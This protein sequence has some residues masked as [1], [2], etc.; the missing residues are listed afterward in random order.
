MK[1]HKYDT[2]DS[3]NNEAMRLLK[4]NE[5][6]HFSIVVAEYQS[7]GKGQVGNVWVSNYGENLLMSIIVFHAKLVAADFF[8][9]T[10]VV[11]VSLTEYLSEKG[12]DA[13]IKWPN[14]IVAEKGKIAG[15][16]IENNIEGSNIKNSVIGIGLNVNQIEFSVF[17]FPGISMK[18]MTNVHF[19]IEKEITELTAIILNNSNKSKA[20]IGALYRKNLYMLGKNQTF[21]QN[22]QEFL[23]KVCDVLDDG[24]LLL[25]ISDKTKKSFAFKEIEWVHSQ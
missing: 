11:T 1:I 18:K 21:R 13:Q 10:R 20:E 23:A 14:D 7:A 6:G 25:Q 22:N 12:I 9:I 2:L 3:T 8:H 16:L 24:R 15:I 17:P 5:S 19:S 4:Q